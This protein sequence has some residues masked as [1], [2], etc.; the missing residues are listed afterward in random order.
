M[1]KSWLYRLGTRPHLEHLTSLVEY[2]NSSWRICFMNQGFGLIPKSWL[3]WL[4]LWHLHEGLTSL[5]GDW[6]L[7]DGLTSLIEDSL[8]LDDLTS[9]IEDWLP[10]DDLTSLIEDWLLLDDLTSLTENWLILY[11]STS[12]IQDLTLLIS[13]C[14]LGLSQSSFLCLAKKSIGCDASQAAPT[15]A[16]VAFSSWF[17]I[18]GFSLGLITTGLLR[19]CLR[20]EELNWLSED[21]TLSWRGFCV[22]LK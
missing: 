5:I 3:H 17:N 19:I 12:L 13:T 6:L 9:S 20:I 10:L 18:D 21:L 7:L 22:A 15:A 8:L 14:H 1:L 11:E 16:E 4:R 2:L